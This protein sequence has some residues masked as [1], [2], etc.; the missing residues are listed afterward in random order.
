MQGSPYKSLYVYEFIHLGAMKLQYLLRMS[1]TKVIG[2]ILEQDTEP[3]N[4]C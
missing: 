2:S 3:Q 4:S 1:D